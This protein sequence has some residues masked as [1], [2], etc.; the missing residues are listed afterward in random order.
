MAVAGVALLAAF[1]EFDK[2]GYTVANTG[3]YEFLDNIVV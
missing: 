2:A 1:K 3:Q